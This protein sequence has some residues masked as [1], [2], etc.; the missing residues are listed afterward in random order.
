MCPLFLDQLSEQIL[1]LF[2]FCPAHSP[3]ND[4]RIPQEILSSVGLKMLIICLTN[5]LNLFE[6]LFKQVM[7]YIDWLTG[8]NSITLR[9]SGLILS[10]KVS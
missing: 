1:F 7:R 10:A 5:R 3:V 4:T 2:G 9:L 6:Q 8:S